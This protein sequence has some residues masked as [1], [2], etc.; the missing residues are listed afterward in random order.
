MRKHSANEKDRSLHR[1][2]TVPFPSSKPSGM[3]FAMG[4]IDTTVFCVV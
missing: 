2:G 1:Q 4:R 3:I